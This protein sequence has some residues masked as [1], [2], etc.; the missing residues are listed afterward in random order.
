MHLQ[1][2]VGF[3]SEVVFNLNVICTD[4]W[5]PQTEK[6]S[7]PSAAPKPIFTI[8]SISASNLLTIYFSSP[9][10]LRNKPTDDFIMFPSKYIMIEVIKNPQSSYRED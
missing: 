5:T 2:S 8:K 1:D 6:I 7:K 3:D 9:I 10:V 4:A